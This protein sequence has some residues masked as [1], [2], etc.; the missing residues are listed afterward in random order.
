MI[1]GKI[2][3]NKPID[4]DQNFYQSESQPLRKVAV[5]ICREIV[6]SCFKQAQWWIFK[7]QERDSKENDRDGVVQGNIYNDMKEDL[8]SDGDLYSGV[9]LKASRSWS[10]L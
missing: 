8:V 3:R 2:Y 5:E 1:T 7:F 10:K 4:T 6:S 9:T